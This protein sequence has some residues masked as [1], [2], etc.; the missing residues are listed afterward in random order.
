MMGWD[1]GKVVK[2]REYDPLFSHLDTHVTRPRGQDA[3]EGVGVGVGSG[4][5]LFYLAWDSRLSTFD[6]RLSTF[7]F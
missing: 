1:N 3:L 6:F 5:A 4:R 2:I 7:D